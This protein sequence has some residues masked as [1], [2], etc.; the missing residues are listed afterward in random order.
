MEI[1]TEAEKSIITYC[2]LSVLSYLCA[3]RFN[4]FNTKAD[5]IVAWATAI[6]ESHYSMKFTKKK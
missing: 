5:G 2:I 3:T 6:D 1:E 4:V